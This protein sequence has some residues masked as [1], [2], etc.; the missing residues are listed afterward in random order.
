MKKSLYKDSRYD[1]VGSSSL[2]EELFGT[3]LKTLTGQNGFS[4][5]SPDRGESKS[6]REDDEATAENKR[7]EKRER[8][9]REREE[10]VRAKLRRME[11]QTERARQELSKEEVEAQF[12]CVRFTA[13][14]PWLELVHRVAHAGSSHLYRQI[15]TDNIREATVRSQ[16]V[17]ILRLIL[18][19]HVGDLEGF[20]TTP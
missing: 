20:L 3:Y 19:C 18:C 14:F 2:R 12:E 17:T 6:N 13:F 5:R 7:R 16:H 8:A 11:V 9:I 15:M 10:G 1:A 4:T